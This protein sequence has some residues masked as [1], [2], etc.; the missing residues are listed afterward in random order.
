MKRSL[1][2]FSVQEFIIKLLSSLLLSINHP[3]E[4]VL[5]FTYQ[6][7]CGGE[8]VLPCDSILLQVFSIYVTNTTM[9]VVLSCACLPTP[10]RAPKCRDLLWTLHHK[11]SP[12]GSCISVGVWKPGHTSPK[13]CVTNARANLYPRQHK[14]N[15]LWH[16]FRFLQ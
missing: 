15:F 7:P 1:S 11:I 9:R 13:F 3:N 8:G 12:W 10:L 4:Q 5:F 16:S 6:D 2:D 14:T